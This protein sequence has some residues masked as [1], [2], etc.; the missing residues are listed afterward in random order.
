MLL[1]S[2]VK[3]A[4]DG[5]VFILTAKLSCTQAKLTKS[6]KK[7]GG[8]VGVKVCPK[9]THLL[10]S[11]EGLKS[12]RK[13]AED[14]K[15]KG[16]PVVTE[17]FLEAAEAAGSWRNVKDP[18]CFLASAP[19]SGGDGGKADG[20]AK[21]TSRKRGARRAAAQD[22]AADGPEPRKKR[23]RRGRGAAASAASAGPLDGKEVAISGRL[24]QTKAVVTRR[25]EDLGGE[26]VN[27]VHDGVD[28]VIV[29]ADAVS[30]A[31][32][33][34]KISAA[35]DHDIP[36][37]ALELLDDVEAS[38]SLTPA[39]IAKHKHDMGTGA[40]VKQSKAADKGKG[41][42]AAKATG[43]GRA[44]AKAKVKDRDDDE[45]EDKSRHVKTVAKGRIPLDDALP[46]DVKRKFHVLDEGGVAWDAML[47]QTNVA[48]KCVVARG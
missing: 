22:A 5:C 8:V 21:D 34:A 27:S 43:K 15:A 18:K 39:L 42:A 12:S 6:I 30:G 25:V 35:R 10:A 26:V 38:G 24:H 4:L 23:A 46:D 31:S 11:E 33:A 9:T 48:N 16:V 14:A 45:E 7:A 41:K 37:V 20:A 19:G 44:T 2:A 13:K 28:L 1:L 40:K 3:M 17:A 29:P 47:N 36:C 32:V